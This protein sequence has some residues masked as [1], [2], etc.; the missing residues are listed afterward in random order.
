MISVGTSILEIPKRKIEQHRV[1][2]IDRENIRGTE[3][4][5]PF[6][7]AGGLSAG[8]ADL[9]DY[10]G[11]LHVPECHRFFLLLQGRLKVRFNKDTMIASA[12]DLLCMPAGILTSRTGIGPVSL[13]HIELEDIPLWSKLKSLGQSVRHYESADLM[14]IFIST[15]NNALRSQDI[16]S[17]RRARESS[18]MLVKLLKREIHQSTN[19][20]CSKHMK[21]LIDLMNAIRA[22]PEYDWNRATI[23]KALNMSDRTMTRSFQRVFNMPPAKMVISIRMDIASRMLQESDLPLVQIAN[24]V[25]YDSP[26]SFS[27]L[28]KIY[29]GVAPGHYRNLPPGGRSYVQTQK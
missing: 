2:L 1:W 15:I 29:T 7:D 19:E 3:V 27:R 5:G 12:G 8:I 11:D 17:I 21:K 23:A 20:W 25:G 28:F 9:P 10:R 14:Y 16:Y 4:A 13:I 6:F 18:E 24:A 26:F 22:H